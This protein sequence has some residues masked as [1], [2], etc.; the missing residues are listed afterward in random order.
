MRLISVI[1]SCHRMPPLL[2]SLPAAL[3]RVAWT[4]ARIVGSSP[5]TSPLPS[6]PTSSPSLPLP[7]FLLLLCLACPVRTSPLV[8]AL[9]DDADEADGA[10]PPPGSQ[11]RYVLN[12]DDNRF[13]AECAV[14]QRDRLL[15]GLHF[16]FTWIEARCRTK[17]QRLC[18]PEFSTSWV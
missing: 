15:R 4:L 5:C 11:V 14:R 2:H 13:E 8:A 16:A 17:A 12:V 18:L 3:S 1:V 6:P 7:C 10:A 9:G